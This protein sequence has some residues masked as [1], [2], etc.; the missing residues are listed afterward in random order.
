MYLPQSRGPY[1]GWVRRRMLGM[2]AGRAPAAPEPDTM[3]DDPDVQL[4]LWMLYEVHFQGFEEAEEGI[5]WDLG[6]LAFRQ[7][8]E[9][10]FETVLRDVGAPLRRPRATAR[11]VDGLRDLIAQAPDP[12]LARFLQRKANADQFVDFLK[13]RSVYHLKEA[14]AHSFVLPR[15]RGG[16]KVA[17]AEVQYDEYGAGRVD[18]LH[19]DLFAKALIACGLDGQ[20]GRYVD[21]ADAATLASSNALSLFCLHRRHRGAALGHLA[22]FESTSSIPCRRISQGAER[23]ELPGEVFDY[24]D[25]HVEADAVHEQIAVTDLCGAL[26]VHEP[27]LATDVLLGAEV[28]LQLGARADQALLDRWAGETGPRWEV[29]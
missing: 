16:V 28:C 29:A 5:E 8:L 13:Q 12:G 22:A 21:S 1:S 6:L 26:V 3:L 17:L 18:R 2:D 4:A 24:F 9:V 7:V 15:V 25:E 19:Q 11:I 14:D 20:Y 23:L 27:E 10:P